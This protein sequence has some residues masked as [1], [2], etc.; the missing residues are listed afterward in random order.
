M[1]SGKSSKR[2]IPNNKHGKLEESTEPAQE[3]QIDFTGKLSNGKI[4]G[5]NQNLNAID[6]FSKWRTVKT[7]RNSEAEEVL[8]FL[9]RNFILYGIPEKIK[10]DKGGAFSSKEYKEIFRIWI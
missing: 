5:E 3:V 2:Q 10:S 6:R 7:C 4:N 9:D 8:N 1:S